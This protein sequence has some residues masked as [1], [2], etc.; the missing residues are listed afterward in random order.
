[1]LF[2]LV[3]LSRKRVDDLREGHIEPPSRGVP[4]LV[5]LPDL[6]RGVR[7]GSACDEGVPL[8]VAHAAVVLAPS[9]LASVGGEVG[10]GD[11]VMHAHL[12]A[13][14]AGE[15]RLSLDWCRRRQRCTLAGDK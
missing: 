4:L 14:K 1:M 9:H 2:D 12:S 5:T 8:T 15:E 13:A 7:K 6:R 3:S 11:V 10:A